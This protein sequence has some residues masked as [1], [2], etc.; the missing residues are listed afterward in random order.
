M[1][2]F[3]SSGL[4]LLLSANLTAACTFCGGD[5]RSQQTLRMHFASAKAVLH[6]KLNNPRFDPKSDQGFT[7]LQIGSILKDD[8]ARG[9]QGAI[10]LRSYLPVVGNTPPEYLIFCGVANGKLDATFGVPATSAV[11][12][13]LKGAAK[14]DD[15]DPAARLGYFFKYLDS[16]DETVAADAFIEFARATDSEILKAAKHIDA[17]KVRK[18]LADSKT[19]PERIGVFAFLLGMSGGRSDAAFLLQQLQQR[20]L[21]QRT[22]NAYGGIL[23]GYV[24]LDPHNGW[25][26]TATIM[27]SDKEPFS[28]RLS[29]IGTVRF[30]QA[31]RGSDCKAEVLKCC[32]ALLPH[33]D[34]ADQAIE[35]LRRWGYWDLTNEVLAQFDKPTHL[36]PIVKRAIV[37]YA[38]CCKDDASNKFLSALRQNDPKLLKSVEETLELYA[39]VKK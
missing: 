27:A 31:S 16:P 18:L 39:P 38:L 5:L 34:L 13:Y 12:D 10:T 25:N 32:A 9:N 37:R 4:A 23:A 8:P 1:R 14:L 17:A 35:D 22:A 21:P 19:P 15:S 6:G 2:R 26:L 24:L 30:F 11:V 3:L 36:A 33:G 7:D 20:P 29:A 28:T